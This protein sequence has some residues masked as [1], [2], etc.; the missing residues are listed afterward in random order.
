M[1]PRI[2]PE[3]LERQRQFH[4]KQPDTAKQPY[5]VSGHKW[6]QRV[7]EIAWHSRCRTLLDYGCGNGSLKEELQRIGSELAVTNYDPV[8]FPCDSLTP[9]DMVVCTDVLEQ[10][11]R[12]FL[13]DIIRDLAA[14]ANRVFLITAQVHPP[15]KHH[16]WL[17]T[18]TPEQWVQ[19]FDDIFSGMPW[20][21]RIEVTR[22]PV[23]VIVTG[24]KDR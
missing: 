17:N 7:A 23:R 2:T 5:G 6:A 3:H 15:R 16:E 4:E 21:I 10:V 9:H 1:K 19:R 12:Q 18:D 20:V 8:T 14:L 24:V 11:E 22:A 13:N